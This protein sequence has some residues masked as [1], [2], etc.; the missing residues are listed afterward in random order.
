MEVLGAQRYRTQ[1]KRRKA[2][3]AGKSATSDKALYP[4]VAHDVLA[5]GSLWTLYIL[6]EAACRA[7]QQCGRLADS[8]DKSQ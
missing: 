2:E 4:S 1:V 5:T 6:P 3:W 8:K 7:P